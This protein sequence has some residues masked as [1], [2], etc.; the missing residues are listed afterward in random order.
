MTNLWKIS[1]KTSFGKV[2]QLKR[3]INLKINVRY[4]AISSWDM[5]KTLISNPIAPNVKNIKK[6]TRKNKKRQN[7]EIGYKI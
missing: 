1:G 2:A 4:G 6:Q 3:N 7:N 5:P